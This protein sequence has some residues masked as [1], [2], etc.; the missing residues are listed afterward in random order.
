MNNLVL[1]LNAYA[2]SG[3]SFDKHLDL[4]TTCHADFGC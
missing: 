2:D 4:G 3:A 1:S